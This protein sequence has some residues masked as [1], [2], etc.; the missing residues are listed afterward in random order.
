MRLSRS[1]A[2]LTALALVPAAC[3]HGSALAPSPPAAGANASEPS[4]ARAK[5]PIKH[6]IV[7]VQENR[8]LE[9]L[10]AGYPGA[11]APMTGLT[12]DGKTIPL[13]PVSFHRVDLGHLWDDAKRDYHYG[14]MNGFDKKPPSFPHGLSPT[15]MYSYVDRTLVRP[16]WELAHR[17]VLADKMFP[18]EWGPSFTAHQNLIAGTT[19]V[20]P[21]QAVINMPAD[22]HKVQTVGCDS[23]KGTRTSLVHK[24]GH[25]GHFT[26][27]FPCFEYPTA[28]DILDSARVSWRYYEAAWS[29]GGTLWDAFRAIKHVRY[30]PDYANNVITAPKQILIDA[31]KGHLPAVSWVTPTLADSDHPGAG[32]D[33]GPSWVASVVNAIGQG[34]DWNSSLIVIVWDD[35]GGWYDNLAPPQLDYRGLGIRVPCLI[36][37]PYAK[38]GFVDHQQFEFGSILKT[39]ETL[40]GLNSLGSTDARASDMLNALDFSQ[41]PRG[42]TPIGAKYPASYFLSRS[43]NPDPPGFEDP[44]E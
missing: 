44:D 26:G 24:D 32:S 1:A 19:E 30:G 28:A 5:Y 11:Y 2:L 21:G 12:H 35:W 3:S 39:I 23:P 13:V 9:N 16:Y 8:S 31:P 38:R 18:T 6:V 25:I 22:N 15:Y 34:P 37:S 4:G 20:K 14:A 29:T 41:A 43:R 36:V 17:Y 33:T 27:P 10:F 42:F 40:Y 7:I